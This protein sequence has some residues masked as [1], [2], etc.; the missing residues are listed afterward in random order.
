MPSDP[1][2]AALE[3]QINDQFYETIA[4]EV[5]TA[6][7]QQV[8]QLDRTQGV[9]D[10]VGDT[11]SLIAPGS[12]SL[13]SLQAARLAQILASASA[14][15]QSGGNANQNDINWDNVYDEAAILL[16]GPQLQAFKA[17]TETIG[18]ANKAKQFYSQQQAGSP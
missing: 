14:R 2:L 9:Q 12:S 1:G 8:I 4:S 10:I 5:G 3:K 7:T 13:T 11:D 15:Y 16:S 18:E 6:V 17:E